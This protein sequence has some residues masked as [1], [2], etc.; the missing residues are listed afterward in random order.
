MRGGVFVFR[1]D[2]PM[3]QLAPLVTVVGLVG[4]IEGG[5]PDPTE[6]VVYD[7]IDDQ[8]DFVVSGNLIA[9]I[10]GDAAHAGLL[11]DIPLDNRYDEPL[12]TTV[13]DIVVHGDS[14]Y[15]I[16]ETGIM[17]STNGTKARVVTM[18]GVSHVFVTDDNSL[19]WTDLSGLAWFGSGGQKQSIYDLVGTQELVL[20]GGE[21]YASAIVGYVMPP[22]M[23]L[24][25]R[26]KLFRVDVGAKS[27]TELLDASQF[28]TEFIDDGHFGAQ[29]MY[30]A[31]DLYALG[32]QL[33]MGVYLDTGSSEYDQRLVERM[34]PSG[35]EQVVAPQPRASKMMLYEGAFY[36]SNEGSLWRAYPD[37]APELVMTPP[38]FVRAIAGGYAYGYM[39]AV[40]GVGFDI[41]RISLS[42]TSG[43]R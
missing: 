20:V 41:R 18:P 2:V 17:S 25:D 23:T 31:S 43:A 8:R 16:D 29:D 19:Y 42:A 3:R 30:K 36:W 38:F 37:G 11:S 6:M 34:T 1:Y 14:V 28:N 5:E 12:G 39:P 4:C 33:Y 15:W 10:D 9:W 32:D 26:S 27:A 7:S 24:V 13:A 35:F 40:S 21:L 22:L